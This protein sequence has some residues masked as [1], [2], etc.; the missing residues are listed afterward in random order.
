MTSGSSFFYS[1]LQ[2]KLETYSRCCPST[3]VGTLWHETTAQ[4]DLAREHSQKISISEQDVVLIEDKIASY[5]M[6]KTR[7]R[8][9]YMDKNQLRHPILPSMKTFASTKS[10]GSLAS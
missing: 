7:T 9:P 5:L 4:A 2:I 10:S 6:K 8:M 3:G 1:S